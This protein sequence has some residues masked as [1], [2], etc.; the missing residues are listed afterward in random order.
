MFV[1]NKS[2]EDIQDLQKHLKLANSVK[3]SFE[4]FRRSSK[5]REVLDI[6]E[7]GV[8]KYFSAFYALFNS[9]R[10]AGYDTTEQDITEQL[11]LCQDKIYK[12]ESDKHQKEWM[13]TLFIVFDS[14]VKRL[15]CSVLLEKHAEGARKMSTHALAFE[16]FMYD[17]FTKRHGA[18]AFK[19]AQIILKAG[20][21]S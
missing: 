19:A 12:D 3:E 11:K 7:I 4:I 10:A 17:E 9:F 13:Y 5:S 21:S 15:D 1:A 6:F 18:R 8:R 14:I 20:A 2:K 16:K